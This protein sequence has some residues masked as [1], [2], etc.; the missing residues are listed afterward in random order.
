M[1][2]GREEEEGLAKQIYKPSLMAA[3]TRG[4]EL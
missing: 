4:W 1:P 2:R 3:P